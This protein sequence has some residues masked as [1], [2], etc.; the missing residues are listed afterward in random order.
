MHGIEKI[1]HKAVSEKL[2]DLDFDPVVLL[3]L[4]AKGDVVSLGLMTQDAYDAEEEYNC[5]D[6]IVKPSGKVLA[7]KIIPLSMR[8]DCARE[9]LKYTHAPKVSDNTPGESR[10]AVHFFLPHNGRDQKQIGVRDAE[11]IPD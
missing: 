9:L 10:D 2:A 7:L 8:R 3:A 1:S 4:L 5:D 11:I 6:I